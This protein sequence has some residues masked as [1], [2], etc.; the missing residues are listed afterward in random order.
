MAA[1][2]VGIELFEL[3]ERADLM[4][5][6]M[7][8]LVGVG[9]GILIIGI[10]IYFFAT[11][12]F[13]PT[14]DGGA[15][16]TSPK[17]N[18]KKKR[19][20]SKKQG[21]QESPEK[22]DDMAFL[23]EQVKLVA[24]EK[25]AREKAVLSDALSQRLQRPGD[26][27][28]DDMIYDAHGNCLCADHHREVC[29]DCCV[30]YKLVNEIER[31]GADFNLDEKFEAYTKGSDNQKLQ[32]AMFRMHIRDGGGKAFELGTDRAQ[33]MFERAE[34]HMHHPSPLDSVSPPQAPKKADSGAKSSSSYSS[35]E[36]EINALGKC[37]AK[38][39]HNPGQVRCSRCKHVYYCS[40][41]C[42]VSIRDSIFNY[43]IFNFQTHLLTTGTPHTMH[44]THA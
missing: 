27:G 26:T 35:S 43:S 14:V 28:G 23:A 32:Q 37:N 41:D 20:K 33:Q 24:E 39:C 5:M 19:K 21:K 12:Q 30:D 40:K 34:Y 15:Q 16:P 42:Q 6:S 25:A 8:L 4:D 18:R 7:E 9:V 17:Q 13:S 10:S 38:G 2:T 3:L 29:Y 44:A 36:S 31:G 1:F 22:D 11:Q